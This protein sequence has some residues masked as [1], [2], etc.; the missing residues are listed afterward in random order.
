VYVAV[1]VPFA[2]SV[3]ELSVPLVVAR[4]TVPALEARLL[5]AASFS[6]TVTVDVLEPSATIEVGLTEIVDVAVDAPA[7]VVVNVG[8][9]P[10]AEPSSACTVCAVSATEL[11]V[12]STVATPLAFVVLEPAASEPPPVLDQVTVRPAVETGLL[13][14]SASCAVIVTVEATVG[15]AELEVTRYLVAAPATKETPAVLV[16]AVPFTVPLTVA[17]PTDVEDV[18]VAVYVPSP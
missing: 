3:T 17:L 14:A 4:V 9:V 6:C 1:Y 18:R 11:T 2:L 13:L 10:E 7:A 15:L 12:K 8:L 5:P 16:I